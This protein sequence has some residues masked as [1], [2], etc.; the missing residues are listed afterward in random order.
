LLA[1]K[2]KNE[3]K[4]NTTTFF[5]AAAAMRACHPL[6]HADSLRRC[7]AGVERTQQK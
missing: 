3:K 2:T 1:E 4:K 6:T 7:T 5:A